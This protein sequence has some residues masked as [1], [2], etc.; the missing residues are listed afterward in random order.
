MRRCCCAGA[1][2]GSGDGVGPHAVSP[3]VGDVETAPVWGEVGGVGAVAQAAE[4]AVGIGS[5]GVVGV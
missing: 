1:G 3:N 4:V 5:R 2:G